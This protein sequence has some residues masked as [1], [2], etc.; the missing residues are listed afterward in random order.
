MP[1]VQV[2]IFLCI[3]HYAQIGLFL[4]KLFF[5]CLKLFSFCL[6]TDSLFQLRVPVSAPFPIRSRDVLVKIQKKHITVGLKG[7]PPI[8]DGELP[9]E[10]KLEES[11]WLLEDNALV[12]VNFEKVSGRVNMHGN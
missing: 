7:Q 8:L 2:F 4:Q 6:T 3:G 1:Y 11:T 5:S 9:H 10:V 12:V